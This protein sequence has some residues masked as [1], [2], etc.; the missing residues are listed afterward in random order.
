MDGN[1]IPHFQPSTT[2]CCKCCM[3]NKVNSGLPIQTPISDDVDAIVLS[4]AR[5]QEI[6]GAE[7]WNETTGWD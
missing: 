1:D 3:D 6:G 5:E 4:N 7:G 2:Q